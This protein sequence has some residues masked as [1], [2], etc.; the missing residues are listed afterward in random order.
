M[1]AL[2]ARKVRYVL[3]VRSMSNKKTYLLRQK[4]ALKQD[5]L[6]KDSY[7]NVK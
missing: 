2:Y 6:V 1:T 5:W 4:K 7:R 3:L